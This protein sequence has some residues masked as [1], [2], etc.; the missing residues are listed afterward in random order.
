MKILITG[1]NTLVPIDK[2]R[3]I[4]NIFRGRTAANI[5]NSA[6][7]GDENDHEKHDVTVLGNSQMQHWLNTEWKNLRLSVYKTYDELYS[8]MKE[9]ITTGKYDAII[10]SAAVSDYQVNRVLEPSMLD[11][12]RPSLPM[13]GKISSNY[14]VLYLELVPTEKI[15]DK[16]RKPWGFKGVLV[17]FKLQVDTSDEKLIEIAKKSRETSEADIIVA[18]CLEWAKERAFII[19]EH[20]C[21]EVERKEL[22]PCLLNYVLGADSMDK[23]VNTGR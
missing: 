14:D 13:G 22:A 2:V 19:T 1:G 17:K 8:C 15:I 21:V 18:N 23:A 9:E 11:L 12:P 20:D 7:Y 3:G 16:I 10:H 6:A 4:T 5:A